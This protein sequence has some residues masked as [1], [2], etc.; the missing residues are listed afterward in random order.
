MWNGRIR[1]TEL[2]Y[3]SAVTITAFAT[4]AGPLFSVVSSIP[5]SIT[6]AKGAELSGIFK[7]SL[8]RPSMGSVPRARPRQSK[9]LSTLGF[10]A[11]SAD[12]ANFSNKSSVRLSWSISSAEILAGYGASFLPFNPEGRARSSVRVVTM[13][14]AMTSSMSLKLL[15]LRGIGC[16]WLSIEMMSISSLSMLLNKANRGSRSL[17]AE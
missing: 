14:P 10:S 9:L 5:F 1:L 7:L 6:L 17:V 2:V 8:A 13:A 11:K 12:F 3:A 16:H 15:G 4:S